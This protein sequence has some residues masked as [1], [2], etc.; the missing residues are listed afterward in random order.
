M[1][2]V[3]FTVADVMTPTTVATTPRD[4]SATAAKIIGQHSLAA[5]PVVEAGRIVGVVTPQ[6]LL[7]SPPYRPVADVMTPGLTP[8]TPTLPLLQAYALMT[9]QHVEILPVIDDGKIVGQVSAVTI[10]RTHS[11]QNDPLT[12]LPAA[13]A[14]RAW[15]VAA[16]EHGHEITVLFIDL[17]NF[18]VVNK[19]LGHVIGDDMLRAVAQLL[20]GLVDPQTDLLCRYG[21]D[22]FAIATTR[23]GAEARELMKRIQEVVVLPVDIGQESRQ[24]TVSVGIAGG[25]RT[26]GRK[27]AHIAATVEDLLTLASHAST[28]AKETKRAAEPVARPGELVNKTALLPRE[29]RR[30]SVPPADTRLRL[31]GVQVQT[32]DRGVAVTVTLRLGP[33]EG[34]GRAAGPVHGQGVLFLAAQATLE[35]I[36]QTAGEA[37]AYVLEELIE[38]PTAGAKFAVAVLAKP[39]GDE[40]RDFLGAAR[41]LNPG[42]AVTKAILDALNRPLARTLAERGQRDVE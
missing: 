30:R 15:A 12:G 22:E 38:V 1:N 27:R 23:Q 13:T 19:T 25:R 2:E 33:R 8:A 9:R 29:E 39:P 37:H 18:G 42:E 31:I 36:R 21:G 5:L 40:P 11:Q 7:L 17:D 28:A 4:T 24:V 16:L 3:L 32:D 26:E 41:A 20:G 14:L 6:Q 10:L 34:V 35:A